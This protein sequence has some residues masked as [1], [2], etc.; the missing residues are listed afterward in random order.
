MLFKEYETC[1]EETLAELYLCG[2]VLNDFNQV[3]AL[4]CKGLM[5]RV[6]F[7]GGLGDRINQKHN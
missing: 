2:E 7:Q 4:L 6:S 3:L 5:Y 1:P